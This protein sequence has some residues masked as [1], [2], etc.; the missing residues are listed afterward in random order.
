MSWGCRSATPPRVLVDGGLRAYHRRR[1]CPKLAMLFYSIPTCVLGGVSPRIV[2]PH[3]WQWPVLLVSEK[4]NF[5]ENRNSQDRCLL[6]H[7]GYRHDDHGRLMPLGSFEIP[8]LLLAAILSVV[9][10]LVLPKEKE[11]LV[12]C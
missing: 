7:R 11:E 12:Q 8:G 9:L 1:F 10:N 2:R 6:A 5:N 3:R 4:V